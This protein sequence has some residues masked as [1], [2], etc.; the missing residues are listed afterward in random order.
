MKPL[1]TSESDVFEYFH[2]V[3][4]EMADW[5]AFI[6]CKRKQRRE[7][8]EFARKCGMEAATAL[9]TLQKVRNAFQERFGSR[10]VPTPSE[11]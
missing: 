7:A 1:D 5:S 4:K 6:L 9:V 10:S 2:E 3:T 11:N 8:L